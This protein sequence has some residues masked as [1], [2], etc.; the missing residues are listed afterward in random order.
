M[1]EK[2]DK[3]YLNL[4]NNYLLIILISLLSLIVIFNSIHVNNQKNFIKLNKERNK[5][6][7][8]K[9]IQRKLEESQ[10]EKC[11]DSNA[12]LRDYY[13][14][15]N[16]ENFKD[17]DNYITY[18]NE[19]EK[20][21]KALINIINYFIYNEDEK[22]KNTINKIKPIK[23]DI[24]TYSNHMIIS[25]IIY[26]III[27]IISFGWIIC[28]ICFC[29]NCCC[30]CCCKKPRCKNIYF[31]I[32]FFLYLF[33]IGISIIC[34]LKS[35][36]INEGIADIKCSIVK[37]FDHI[38]EGETKQTFPKWAGLNKIEEIL[39]N[40]KER[41][42]E[43]KEG[44]L[45]DLNLKINDI[46]NQKISFKKKMEESGNEFYSPPDRIT[47]S[48]LYS[49]DN[50]SIESRGITGRYTLDLV[51]MFGRK[52]NMND[53]E[54]EKYEPENSILE[55]W[56]S[57]YKNISKNADNNIGEI[58]N[59]FNNITDN[60]NGDLIEKLEQG[61]DN[62]IKLKDFFNNINKDIEDILIISDKIDKYTMKLFKAFFIVVA[63][64][65]FFTIVLI[66][67]ICIFAG[68]NR[69]DICCTKFFFGC[70]PHILLVFLYLIMII[71][72]ILGIIFNFFG[73]IGNDIVS[74]ISYIISKDNLRE[75]G[76]NFLVANLGTAKDYL[77]KCFNGDGKIIDLFNINNNQKNSL[78]DLL[79]HEK[80]INNIKTEFQKRKTFSTYSFYED[81]LKA[82]YNLSIIPMLIKD[83]YEIS[84][85]LKDDINY[86]EQ[87]DKYLKFDIELK[88]MNN[89]IRTQETGTNK[90]EQWKI[91]SNSPNECSIGNDPNFLTYEFNPL[92]C[93]PINRD[94]IQI[95]SNS[96]IKTEAQIIS[97]T[98]TF[99]DNAIKQESKSFISIL[100][101]LKEEY[102][103][104]L[105]QYIITLDSFNK[106]LNKITGKIK[107]YIN[108][109]DYIFS[110]MNGKIIGVDL[111]I[112][113]KYLKTSLGKDIKN[114]SYL[115]IILGFIITLSIS[116]TLLFLIIIKIFDYFEFEGRVDQ[117]NINNQNNINTIQP[118]SDMRYVTIWTGRNNQSE[119][120]RN[121]YK[122]IKKS[123][124]FKEDKN[125][126]E[127]YNFLIKGCGIPNNLL[128]KKGNCSRDWNHG[129]ENGPIGY[130]KDYIPPQGWIGIGLKVA[131]LY[132]NGNNAWLENGQGK[133]AW[134]K[135]YHGVKSI[136]A[137]KGI[138]NEGFRRGDGQSYKDSININSLNNKTFPKVGEGVYFTNDINEAE[139]YTNPINYK[140]NNYKIVFMCRINPYKVRIADLGG[141]KEY[142]VV[143]GDKLGDLY[144][145]KKSDQVRPYRILIKKIN[146]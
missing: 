139:S 104:Y 39:N 4:N 137:I 26:L 85:P 41:I 54:E 86:E 68:K 101:N 109:E 121:S 82:R 19:D 76:N 50:Y 2:R 59:D 114:F 97:D 56:H 123:Y 80:Q 11:K 136:E 145:N 44:S 93:R 18:E 94:W 55:T 36:S 35:N 75:N 7:D 110:F 113:L 16:I 45:N 83:D 61:N 20:Y 17:L 129:E 66:F 88:L 132:D 122:E 77:N 116:I 24:K 15:G 107:Q 131:S 128:D 125:I 63:I 60:T 69:K 92:K 141:N 100:K 96:D 71:L 89:L 99:L 8:K 106:A 87:A 42:K 108:N 112:M 103:E 105:D 98:L 90:N 38:L 117:N 81:Q 62:I 95:K 79:K 53:S 72:F 133:G 31:W 33:S 57:E 48:N 52:A 40:M 64:V 1:A 30:C 134:Y 124:S 118:V 143:D 22:E 140:G 14:T 91:N 138:C 5:P 74:V 127:A 73:N 115:L 29:C 21:F 46:N 25:I 23:D 135:G 28:P 58:I 144:G 111:K 32:I 6:F 10:D 146:E 78:N 27:I 65:N 51:K 34:F 84:L 119:I 47:Y 126:E 130:S 67:F 43:L 12:N 13:N 120:S 142:W 3:L 9:I 37:F 102:S 49:S 70:L